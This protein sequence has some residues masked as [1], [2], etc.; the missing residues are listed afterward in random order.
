[1]FED[2]KGKFETQSECVVGGVL[3]KIPALI[4][5]KSLNEGVADSKPGDCN[6][7]S[8][9]VNC[10]KDDCYD[11][12]CQECLFYQNYSTVYVA[13][14]AISLKNTLGKT[15]KEIPKINNEIL[16]L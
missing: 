9:F 6:C 1:M 14:K 7:R 12:D 11:I 4:G 13:F 2:L 8:K 16:L 15:S 3:Y 10:V 5:F